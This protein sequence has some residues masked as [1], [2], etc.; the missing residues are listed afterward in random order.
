MADARHFP[1]YLA[2][3]VEDDLPGWGYTGQ[4][5][6]VAGE[7]VDAEFLFQQ[8]DL[9]ADSWLGREKLRCS[10]RDVQVVVRDL[11]DIAKLLEFHRYCWP[12]VK[13]TVYRQME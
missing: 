4:A 5:L 1:E 11:P 3:L 6:A 2:N 13:M 8:T 7:Y 10:R 12:G 9:F